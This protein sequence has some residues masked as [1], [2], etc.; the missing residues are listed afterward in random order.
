MY[1]HLIEQ[2]EVPGED[3]EAVAVNHHTDWPESYEYMQMMIDKG[4][5]VTVIE[6]NVGG[7]SD[8]YS[9]S[10]KYQIIPCRHNRWCTDKFKIK[11]LY[12]HVERP[13]VMLIG[14]DAGEPK[15]AKMSLDK[16]II[17]DFPLIEA[18][19]DRQ[20]CVDLIK[21]HGLPVPPKSGC[22]ICPFQRRGQWSELRE[23]YPELFCKARLL[24]EM[25]NT[26]RAKLGKDPIY[27]N[28][29]P[30]DILIQVKDS[31]GRRAL[32]G[33]TEYFDT[34]DRPPCRC[35]L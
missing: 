2:G 12:K 15:R 23:Q 27:F 5:P 13:C 11:P 17:N 21:R 1:L 33:Q 29:I 26:R 4:Y 35:G 16:E 28:D 20:G 14:F 10:L 30:L 19:I 32:P 34:H 7:C 8:I 3:F 22:W 25:C 31:R 18:G 6:A 9:Y 24:E